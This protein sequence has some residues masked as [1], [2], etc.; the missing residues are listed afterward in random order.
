MKTLL[1]ELET[2]LFALRSTGRCCTIA[3]VLDVVGP[4]RAE[5]PTRIYSLPKP[6]NCRAKAQECEAHANIE[7]NHRL[8]NFWL[9]LALQ[10]HQ[11][12]KRVEKSPWT[13]VKQSQLALELELRHSG[14]GAIGE[15]R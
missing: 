8:R 10:W 3:P 9:G 1:T 13:G 7:R 12:A 14:G 5:A 6:E 2:N 11:L 15:L 4:Q